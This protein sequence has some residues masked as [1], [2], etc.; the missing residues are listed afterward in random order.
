MT[1]VSL[2][3]PVMFACLTTLLFSF[4]NVHASSLPAVF[5]GGVIDVGT[6]FNWASDIQID[7]PT[8]LSITA[9]T[10][11]QLSGNISNFNGSTAGIIKTGT[12]SL[13]LHGANTYSG[14]TV[15][16]QGT[17]RVSGSQAAGSAFRT[18]ELQ[19][20]TELDYAPNARLHNVLALEPAAGAGSPT[21]T[22][23]PEL[24][25]RLR[26]DQGSAIQAGSIVGNVVLIKLGQGTLQLERV[27]T[28]PSVARVQEGTLEINSL[29]G[30]PI[31]VQNTATLAGIGAIAGVQVANA[32]S[33][34]AGSATAAAGTASAVGE[35]TITGNLQL[36]AGS[37]LVVDALPDGRADHIRVLGAAVLNGTV[38][39]RTLDANWQPE[40]RYTLISANGG[41]SGR[42]TAAT[43][44]LPFLQP[45]LSYDADHAYLTLTRNER[46]LD[47]VIDEPG[48]NDVGD[49]VN[50]LVDE[51]TGPVRDAVL[52]QTA[53]GA[54]SLLNKL[55][56]SWSASVLSRLMQDSRYIRQV[57]LEQV[58]MS[59]PDTHRFWTSSYTAGARR[60]G[61]GSADADQRRLSGVAIGRTVLLDRTTR[62]AVL[63]GY[64]HSAMAQTNG[65]AKT[66]A[67][68]LHAGAAVAHQL[69]LIDLSLGL[70]RSWHRLS[71][72]R[73]II[74][75]RLQQ[76]LSSRYRMRTLQ[77]FGEAGVPLHADT[78]GIHDKTAVELNAFARAAWVQMQGKAYSEQGG[79]A[80]LAFQASRFQTRLLELGLRAN[81]HWRGPTGDYQ[82][83]GQLAWHHTAGHVATP[84]Q[85][86]FAQAV[87]ARRFETNGL[88]GARNALGIQLALRAQPHRRISGALSYTSRL[89]KGAADH[90]ARLDLAWIF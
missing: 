78:G 89:A 6:S 17:L 86:Q 55:A 87:S 69:G 58:S 44:S 42:F 52:T 40:T 83:S 37:S 80:A 3:K 61:Q 81:K 72:Q 20:G 35:L 66:Q 48:D 47:S 50:D 85:A 26:V 56:G 90:S 76:W 59:Q 4:G 32:G 88:T 5:N 7:D 21:I 13:A 64:E 30:G 33:L 11:L 12:G 8:V 49:A 34:S 15:V 67:A 16:Q 60:Q 18:V 51:T 54:R 84:M 27:A 45:S 73:E 71:G 79:S 43:A 39:T 82:A 19:A 65:Q 62:A 53:E 1:R 9:G 22:D 70:V 28:T 29:F 77:V 2:I 63:A 36:D 25:V 31:L 68:T 14:N 74:S 10:D 23:A 75:Q 38:T 46:P 24:A 41:V 57:T